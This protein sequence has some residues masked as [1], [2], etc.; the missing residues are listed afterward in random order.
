[1]QVII[2]FYFFLVGMDSCGVLGENCGSFG[3]FLGEESLFFKLVVFILGCIF[4]LFGK[5][6]KLEVQE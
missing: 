5:F 4:E 6:L 3:Y 2:L 1:M